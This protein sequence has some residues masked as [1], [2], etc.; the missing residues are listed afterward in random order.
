MPVK[1]IFHTIINFGVHEGIAEYEN[2]RLRFANLMQLFCQA[3]YLFYFVLGLLIYAPLVSII[4]GS[5]LVTGWMGLIFNRYRHYNWGRSFFITSFCVLLFFACNMPEV[6][7]YFIPFY[8]PAF[9]SFTLYYDLEKDVKNAA[10]NLT[11]SVASAVFAVTL[12]DL[13]HYGQQIDAEWVGFIRSLN[14]FLAFGLTILFMSF[15]VLHI[16]KSGRLLIEAKE[17]AELAAQAKSRF[18]SNMSHEMRTP[19]NGIIGTVNLL[20]QETNQQDRQHYLEVLKHSSEHMFSVVNDVL[21][22]SKMEADKMEFSR[23]SFN[24]KQFLENLHTVF[25]NQFQRK[26][27]ALEFHIDDQLDKNFITDETRLRQV[28]N[29]LLGNAQKFTDKGKVEC[30]VKLLSADSDK[31][32]IYFSIKDTGI[33]LSPEK[34]ELVFEAFNQGELSTTRRYGGTGL[35]LT[36]SKRIIS[37]LGSELKVE[38]KLRKGS[39]FYFTLSLPFGKNRSVITDNNRIGSLQSLKGITVLVAEDSAINMKI[40]RRFLERWEVSVS[41]AVN[42]EEAVKAVL[43]N[44]YD[45][46]LLDLDMPVMDGFTALK[47]IRKF[48]KTIPVIAFTAAVLPEMKKELTEKGFTDFLQKPFR[49]EELHKVIGKYGNR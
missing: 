10:M 38:S 36:I 22:F 4:T 7:D 1:R 17:K 2:E 35:G 46:L 49:P 18:L 9:M 8:F 43:E 39:T 31:A 25:L 19:L 34:M 28:L 42:G 16:Y 21:D 27:V 11:I 13:F 33:G 15:T 45:L 5:M 40:A 48:N 32:N 24:M 14:Y 3:F 20:L 23:D 26:K 41:E 30:T 37:N 29:N 6:G 12:P 44:N 47:E